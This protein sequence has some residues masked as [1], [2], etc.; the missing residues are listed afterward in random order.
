MSPYSSM[1]FKI[2]K[3]NKPFWTMCLPCDVH[4]VF[5]FHEINKCRV[6]SKQTILKVM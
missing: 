4:F 2:Q 5:S 3:N 1:I 6:K